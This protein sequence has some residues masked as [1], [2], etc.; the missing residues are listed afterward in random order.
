MKYTRE[1]REKE[2]VKALLVVVDT[3]MMHFCQSIRL[4][5][6]IDH[7]LLPCLDIVPT[8]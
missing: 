4:E 3:S 7:N 5:K 6:I 2:N 1:R 8:F